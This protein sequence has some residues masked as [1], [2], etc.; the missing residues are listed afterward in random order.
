MINPLTACSNAAAEFALIRP[1]ILTSDRHWSFFDLNITVKLNI[2]V[3]IILMVIII[4]IVIISS[5]SSS[6]VYM[7]IR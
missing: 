7:N 3:I 2:T 5:S 1:A 6:A 4:V